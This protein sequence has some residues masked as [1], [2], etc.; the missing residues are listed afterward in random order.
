[1]SVIVED[2][3][4]GATMK[5]D[6][7]GITATR[8]FIVSEITGDGIDKLANALLATGIPTVGDLYPSSLVN[9]VYCD[10]VTATP[11]NNENTQF[12]VV[13]SYSGSSALNNDATEA[14][15]EASLTVGATLQQEQTTKNANGEDIVLIPKAE[16]L[17]KYLKQTGLISVMRPQFTMSFT[18]ID[19]ENP[20]ENAKKYVGK[21]NS[22]AFFNN[23]S[24]K[25]LCTR[26]EGNSKD[27][28]KTY[29]TTYQFQIADSWKA[30]IAYIDQNNGLPVSGASFE[31]GL[32]NS[33]DVYKEADFNALGF[34]VEDGDNFDSILHNI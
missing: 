10:S 23:E 1:M 8:V 27:N 22:N 13:A 6:N 14:T 21:I 2:V 4:R 18:R 29:V 28:G 11:I 33:A 30:D 9:N 24:K 31:N 20:I 5:Q 26:I 25:V 7:N 19:D 3:I 16:M 32:K 15:G 17:G 34:D 12:N